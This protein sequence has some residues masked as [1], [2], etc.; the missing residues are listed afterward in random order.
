MENRPPTIISQGDMLVWGNKFQYPVSFTETQKTYMYICIHIF[1]QDWK[2]EHRKIDYK[3]KKSETFSKN[4][5]W[6]D[7]CSPQKVLLK[8]EIL[9]H[10]GCTVEIAALSGRNYIL[11]G[12]ICLPSTV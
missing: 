7:Y 3:K 1:M 12:A 9:H 6:D 2:M 10:L 4:G 5:I 8:E 11:T